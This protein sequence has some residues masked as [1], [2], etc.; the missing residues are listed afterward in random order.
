MCWS[1][2][3]PSEK[4]SSVGSHGFK[5]FHKCYIFMVITDRPNPEHHTWVCTNTQTYVYHMHTQRT[6]IRTQASMSRHSLLQSTQNLTRH[7]G[8]QTCWLGFYMA[9]I[10]RT[11]SQSNTTLGS[12]HPLPF[13]SPHLWKWQGFLHLVS[14]WSFYSFQIPPSQSPFLSACLLDNLV[15]IASGNKIF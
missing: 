10:F 1:Y 7:P 15:S 4:N 8:S 11:Q 6:R 2:I 12:G 9:L 14:Q 13:K 3:W 5:M